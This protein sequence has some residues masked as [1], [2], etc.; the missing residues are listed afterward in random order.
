MPGHPSSRVGLCGSNLS[1]FSEPAGRGGGG[2]GDLLRQ[3][4]QGAITTGLLIS[5]VGTY[6]FT[7]L[8]GALY[9]HMQPAVKG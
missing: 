9:L 1:G 5:E 2:I 6:M 3:F 7:M 8:D 4:P